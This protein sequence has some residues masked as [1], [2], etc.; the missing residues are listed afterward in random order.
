MDNTWDASTSND[1]A[2]VWDGNNMNNDANTMNN[3]ANTW[4]ANNANTWDS[5]NANTW[6]TTNVNSMVA[7]SDNVNQPIAEVG[8]W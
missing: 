1:I 4:D 8:G 3:N 6:D 2:P 7:G 5:N